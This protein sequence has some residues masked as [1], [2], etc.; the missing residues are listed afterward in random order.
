MAEM[1]EK[2]QMSFPFHTKFRPT[3]LTTAKENKEQNC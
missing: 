2:G 3:V 1:Q